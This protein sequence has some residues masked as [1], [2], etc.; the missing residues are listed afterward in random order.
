MS[1]QIPEAEEHEKLVANRFGVATQYIPIVTKTR[2]LHKNYVVTLSKF[3]V[4][5]S[6]KALREQVT[7]ED[8]MPRQRPVTKSENS[9]TT[10]LSMSQQSNQF[11]PEFWGS[12][13]QLMKCGPT[14]ASL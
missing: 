9:F 14:L 6:K 3:V 2:L 7:T 4:T 13:T 8:C 12:T 11:G 5:E 10:E 1:R